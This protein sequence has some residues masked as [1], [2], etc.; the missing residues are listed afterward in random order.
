M[1]KINLA[2]RKT[3]TT[4]EKA[5]GKTF[6]FSRT[7]LK[8]DPAIFKDP[9]FR[10]VALTIIAGVVG[11]IVVDG[12]KQD[13]LKK[14][15]DIGLR[16]Q[17]ESTDLQAKYEKTK[18]YEPIKKQLEADEET[19]RTKLETV[20]KLI[21]DRQTPPKLIASLSTG[22]PKDVWLTDFTMVGPEIKVKGVSLGLNQVSDMMS[23][24]DQNS[25][26][27][28]VKLVNTNNI[29]DEV[30]GAEVASFELSAKRK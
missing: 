21:A 15:D 6:A 22:I 30:T 3:S 10:K 1:I 16:L 28:D 25:F 13:E 17:A 18:A 20:Q 26:V 23:A 29:K 8:L 12:L 27:S 7:T 19:I 11:Y 14:W 2:L 4:A 5:D 24:L 9:Q